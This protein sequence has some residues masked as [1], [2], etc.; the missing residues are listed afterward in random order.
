MLNTE[1]YFFLIFMFM[2][3]KY[4]KNVKHILTYKILIF[5]IFGL[6]LYAQYF[7]TFTVF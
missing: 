2:M 6:M 4:R 1:G 5:V 3:E 7:I